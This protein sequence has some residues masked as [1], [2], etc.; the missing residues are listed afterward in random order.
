[1]FTE[2]YQKTQIWLS[3]IQL[4]GKQC[5]IMIPI[6]SYKNWF[7]MYQYSA[8]AKVFLSDMFLRW[9]NVVGRITIQTQS[10]KQDWMNK[11]SHNVTLNKGWLQDYKNHQNNQQFDKNGTIC[12]WMEY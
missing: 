9:I 3:K 10:S 2:F 7:C 11:G 4:K 8:P 6:E 12:K 1:M 5:D